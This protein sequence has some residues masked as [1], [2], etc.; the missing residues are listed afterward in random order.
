MIGVQEG[1][2][3]DLIGRYLLRAPTRGGQLLRRLAA[4]TLPTSASPPEGWGGGGGGYDG[5][6]S[7]DGRDACSDDEA[8]V[9][10]EL[11][12]QLDK[13]ED[14]LLAGAPTNALCL[15]SAAGWM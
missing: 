10:S 12:V 13:A 4:A 11:S 8:V 9:F 7:G 5:R 6:A 15:I 3:A 2:R 14:G 1:M